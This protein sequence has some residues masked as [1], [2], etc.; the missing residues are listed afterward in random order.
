MSDA[1]LETLALQDAH[2]E[3]RARFAPFAGWN[4]PLQYRGIVAEHRAVRQR[5]GVFDVSHMGRVRLEGP[6]AAER[7]R[8]ATTYDTRRLEAG[9]AHYTL[10]CTREGGIA[11]DVFVFRLEAERWLVVHNA[12]NAEAGLRRLLDLGA[13]AHD[14]TRETVMLAV[15]GPEARSTVAAILGE[16]VLDVGLRRC[17]EVT[18]RDGAVLVARTGY[19][20]EDGFEVIAPLA[21]GRRLWD[22]LLA[23]GV[24]PAGLGARDTLRLE[25]ALPLHGQ[26]IDS[27]TTPY[28]A[29]LGWTVSLDD[30]APFTGQEA[31]VR[32]SEH[33]P[34]RRLAPL[35]LT[36]RGVPR[37]G[38]PVLDPR[39]GDE[40]ST[41]TSGSFSPT[42]RAG[43]GMA[44]LPPDRSEPGTALTVLIRERR[45]PAEVVAR[46][47][48]RR[49]R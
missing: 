3:S 49:P 47:F 30:G 39:S 19:T 35:R 9:E 4:M 46:P 22:R 6:G 28:E 16:A 41:L 14:V 12:A 23:A 20:G 45:V 13:P 24:E 29:G 11:D 17:T 7:L 32:L 25:A 34:A 31:L 26:D 38:C 37:A 33:P 8:L 40:V 15:Q 1:R 44:Y 36:V 5:A 42:L 10:Y 2:A 48:Y 21:S 18:Y 43:I 27:T